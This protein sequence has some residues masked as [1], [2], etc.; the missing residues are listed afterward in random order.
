MSSAFMSLLCSEKAMMEPAERVVA[1]F[2]CIMIAGFCAPHNNIA[3]IH[4][5][6]VL[7]HMHRQKMA[8]HAVQELSHGVQ[9]NGVTHMM[10]VC[11]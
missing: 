9:E 10:L 6:E 5:L 7:P 3:M 2:L 11:T 8:K 1:F 4:S